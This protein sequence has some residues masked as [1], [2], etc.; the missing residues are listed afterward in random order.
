MVDNSDLFTSPCPM[1][2]GDGGIPTNQASG[3][4]QPGARDPSVLDNTNLRFVVGQRF[5]FQVRMY[6]RMLCTHL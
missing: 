2:H 1:L 6:V 5:L 4:T 3:D